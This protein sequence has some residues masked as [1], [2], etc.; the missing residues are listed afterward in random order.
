M[1]RSLTIAN[2]AGNNCRQL[3][4]L[5]IAIIVSITVYS[6]DSHPHILVNPQ[7]KQIILEKT[8][9]YPWAKKVF[10][11]MLSS[12]EPYVKKHASEPE[13]IL[14]RYLM[15]RTAGKRY[16]RFYSDEDGTALIRYEGDAP[17]PTIRVSPHKRPPITADGYS[18]KT[19]KIE[20]LV[21]YDTSM[22]MLLTTN[23]PDGR[24]EWVDPQAF[25]EG[26]NG[27]INQLALDAAIIYW[28]TGKE[29][30]AVFAA[31]IINQWARGAYYQQPIV[32]PC[33]TGFLSIQTLGDRQYAPLTLA[34]DFLYDFMRSKK[35]ET[36]WYET[37]F[38]KTVNTMTFRGYWNNNWFA[39]QTPTMVFNALS[40]ED[41]KKREYYL[42]F[43]LNKDTINGACGHLAM[44]SVLEKWLTPDGH[45][46]EPGGYH[47]FPVSSL[48]TSALAL[49]NN[50]YN[51]FGKYPALL[52]SSYVLLKYSFPN[53]SA[54]SI[55]DTGPVSQSTD[56]LEIGLLMAK[57][58]GNKISDDLTAAMDV[59]IK[60][61]GYKRESND[62]LGLLC[63]L[64]EIPDK[65]GV[66]YSWPRSGELDFAKCY[67][68]RNGSNRKTGLMYVVQGATYNHN[69]AN[70]MSLELY[71]AGR[72]M[73]ID[74]GKGLTYEAP[75]HVSYYAQWA[76]HNTV[77]SGGLS[78]SVP[79]FTGGGGTKNMGEIKLAAMEPMAEKPAVSLFCSF[80]DTRYTDI[81]TNT[82]QQRSLSIIRTSDNTGYY[83]DIYRSANEKSNEYVYHNIGNELS[84]LDGERKPIT[85]KPKTFPISRQPLDPPGFRNILDYQST[86]NI[87]SNVTALFKLENKDGTNDYM[88][89]LFTGE[90]AREFYS[91][92]GP[93]S[94]TA[95]APFRSLPTPTLV[96]RQEGEAWKR[97]FIAVYEPF[98]GDNNN[99]V[100]KI[101]IEERSSS[102]DF[103]AVNVYNK[104][105]SRQLLFQSI[106]NNTVYK[107]GSWQFKGN[108]GVVNLVNNQ[109]K[110]LYL[111][112]GNFISFQQYSLEIKSQHGAANLSV[113]KNNELEISCNQETTISIKA[114][115]AKSIA[116]VTADKKTF[117]PITK[118]ADGISFK[119]P[120][121]T[122]S[123]IQINK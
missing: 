113:N 17:Y 40:L 66:D 89:V 94:G 38:E 77:V 85:A 83:L 75:L 35:Y 68:Q 62:F 29:E 92:N 105:K 55:G 108:F 47:T 46:K 1:K 20:E 86:G 33:R 18:Y 53:F 36:S 43:Y 51:V 120:A 81:S 71:G 28:L 111:G 99:S 114:G 82:K 117:I 11:D 50:G 93:E 98:S 118:T 56:C 87:K 4:S 3:L 14:S 31:D 78:G 123:I 54:P 57:K 109:L 23:A 80:T 2:S 7:D 21:P 64:P 95:D 101:A 88:Q 102:G 107:K 12:V 15:N 60:Q 25:V 73:G 13:W 110:Y 112:D 42:N 90:D 69:H 61:K 116:I 96:S 26:I 74:P 48:L 37:V 39:A 30:Y 44:P 19:P 65:T 106:D 34:Y 115:S 52:Q 5:L 9:K 91:G 22:K 100:E 27:R 49:E 103:V 79:Y 8:N 58:Y 59:M 6:Q 63:Y 119:V 104:D 72:V 10:D 41:K 97:P 76:A 45:W 121:T 32:G 16:T 122:K 67:L 24:K 84:F 70:G